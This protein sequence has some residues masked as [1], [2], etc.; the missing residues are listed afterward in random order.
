MFES[1]AFACLLVRQR[2]CTLCI[3]T[4]H[5]K[6]HQANFLKDCQENSQSANRCFHQTV[7]VHNLSGDYGD[8]CDMQAWALRRDIYSSAAQPPHRLLPLSQKPPAPPLSPSFLQNLNVM[9]CT[10]C[11]VCICSTTDCIMCKIFETQSL[12]THMHADLVD[13]AFLP[14]WQNAGRQTAPAPFSRCSH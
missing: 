8:I 2:L 6:C 1:K 12:S 11:I 13:G 9:T 3:F 14:R 5:H 10:I 4:A 7:P